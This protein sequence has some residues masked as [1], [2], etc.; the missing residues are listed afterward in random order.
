MCDQRDAALS[1]LISR[2]F[3]ISLSLFPNVRVDQRSTVRLSICTEQSN[4]HGRLRL[5]H[6]NELDQGLWE[7]LFDAQTT[8]NIVNRFIF[9]S[10]PSS[11]YEYVGRLVTRERAVNRKPKPIEQQW[12]HRTNTQKYHQSSSSHR[13][14]AYEEV[15]VESGRED[16]DDGLSQPLGVIRINDRHFRES[17]RRDAMI[18]SENESLPLVADS[19]PFTN[20]ST[21]SE[22]NLPSSSIP[23]T[24]DH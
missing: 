9:R 13:A 1:L 17:K 7:S 2:S 3:C 14:N 10:P 22:T 19:L 18:P 8:K 11:D 4:R 24:E 20:A 5:R 23:R 21:K 15:Q 12:S 6:R 16:D